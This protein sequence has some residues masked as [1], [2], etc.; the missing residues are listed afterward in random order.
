M[1]DQ[2]FTVAS[3]SFL[4]ALGSPTSPHLGFN[5][6]A[7]KLRSLLCQARPR[8]M[9][10]HLGFKPRALKLHS[11]CAHPLS[12]RRMSGPSCCPSLV[13]FVLFCVGFCV[14]LWCAAPSSGAAQPSSLCCSNKPFA[15]STANSVSVGTRHWIEVT[16]DDSGGLSLSL[17]NTTTAVAIGLGRGC[18]PR[19]SRRTRFHLIT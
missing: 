8:P 10:P 11:C 19:F 6:R 17:I 1:H 13:C 9:S 5:P 14:P 15:A 4:R 7:L 16:V 12:V 3:S 2:N 18:R